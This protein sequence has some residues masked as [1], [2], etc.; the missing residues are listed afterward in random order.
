MEGTAPGPDISEEEF[1]ELYERVWHA[2]V[3]APTL[4]QSRPPSTPTS[5]VPHVAVED[6]TASSSPTRGIGVLFVCRA[7][8]I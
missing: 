8:R 2:Y 4:P 7:I 6:R 5:S 1:N 3:I